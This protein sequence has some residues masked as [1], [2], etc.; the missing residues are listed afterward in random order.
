MSNP[1][2]RQFFEGVLCQ[3]FD[4]SCDLIDFVGFVEVFEWIASGM[5]AIVGFIGNLFIHAHS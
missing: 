1:A 4:L 5:V 2:R 3:C